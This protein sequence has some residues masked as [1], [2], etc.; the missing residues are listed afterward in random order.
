M[1]IR[2]RNGLTRVRCVIIVDITVLTCSFFSL[3]CRCICCLGGLLSITALA[4][5][6]N[7]NREIK[8]EVIVDIAVPSYICLLGL[9]GKFCFDNIA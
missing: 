8:N 4:E 2:H 5:K 6:I 7:T 1:L 3:I 9:N